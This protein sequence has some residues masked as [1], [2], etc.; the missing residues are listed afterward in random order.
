MKS[1]FRFFIILTACCLAPGIGITQQLSGVRFT[2]DGTSNILNEYNIT[3]TDNLDEIMSVDLTNVSKGVHQL[4]IQVRDMNGH[5]THYVRRMILVEGAMGMTNLLTGEYFFDDDPGFGNGF[6]LLIPADV[7]LDEDIFISIPATLSHGVHILF[8]RVKDGGGQWSLYARRNILVEGAL[9]MALLEDAEYFFDADPGFGNGYALLIPDVAAVDEDVFISIPET[10]LRGVHIL[11]VRTQ[12][13]GGQ[14]SLYA[15]RNV[16]VEGAINMAQLGDAEYF[17][18]TDPGFGNGISVLLPDGAVV[19]ADIDFAVPVDLTLG[20]HTMY[21]RT[22]DQG[23]QWSHYVYVPVQICEMIVPEITV[24]GGVCEG[25]EQS[26]QV[27]DVYTQY[28]WSTDE[29]SPSITVTEGDMYNVYVN[30]GDCGITV[31]TEVVYVNMPIPLISQNINVLTCS[32]IGYSYQ[33]YLNGEI[34]P[35]ANGQNYLATED[36]TYTV[37]ITQQLCQEISPA[38]DFVFT[39]LTTLASM[40]FYLFP[41]PVINELT[42]VTGLQSIYDARVFDETGRICYHVRS[43]DPV[44][45]MPADN[46]SNGKYVLVLNSSDS[47]LRKVFVVV[48]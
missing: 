43:A 48:R 9:N 27:P 40:E 41:N 11:F 17:F 42:V 33:W 7:T 30:D 23:G 20:P 13:N 47:V 8:V 3:P 1:A 15:R 34:I 31:S 45:Q 46:F 19:D 37:T 22:Q 39:G 24:S 32:E 12:D 38:F 5:W 18:D 14:W 4:Y 21:V 28:L 36:G 29:T 35:L 16:L 26:L 44:L 2:L 10:M 6:A 25:D